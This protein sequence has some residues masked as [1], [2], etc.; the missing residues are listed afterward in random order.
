MTHIKAPYNF[1]PL[2]KDVVQPYW[3]R[4]ISHDIPFEDAQSGSLDVVLTAHS[5][6]F[7]KNGMRKGEEDAFYKNNDAGKRE[8][9][10]K[11]YPFNQFKGK[12]FIPGSS[13]KGMVRAVLEIMSFGRM[14]NK[15]N[16]HRYALRDFSPAMKDTYL[17]KFTPDEI[18]AGWLY[19][20][21]ENN[22]KII[23]CRHPGRISHRQLDE[24]LNTDFV[25]HF[26]KNGA[27]EKSC[28]ENKKQLDYYKSA[29]YKYDY[30]GKENPRKFAFIKSVVQDTSG[31]KRY[32]IFKND[33][34][35]KSDSDLGKGI[36]VFTGQTGPRDEK[37]SER[38]G[39]H[40]G[41]GHHL[42]FVFFSG[43]IEPLD[44]QGKVMDN[45]FFAYFEHDNTRWSEDYKIRREQLN[46]EEKI[47][48]FFQ[49]DENGDVKH[50]GLSYM[51]KVPFEHS[52][53]EAIQLH[54]KD[55][56]Y[57]LAEIIFGFTDADDKKF[58]KGRVHIGHAFATNSPE[59]DEEKL[60]VLSGPKASYYPNY[61]RQSFTNG[62]VRRY[63]SFMDNKPEIAGWKRYP[64]HSNGIK[65]NPAPLIKGKLNKKILTQFTPLKT[66]A[67]FKF[68]IRYHNLKKIELG[69]LLS[70][71]TF[72][73]TPNTFHSIGMAKPLGYGKVNLAVSG[74]EN[75]EEC[76]CAFESYMNIELRH[77]V[78]EWGISEQMQDLISMVSEQQNSGKSELKYMKLN[79]EQRSNDFVNAKKA[80]E[81]LER[82]S[83]LVGST[84]MITPI[85]SEAQIAKMKGVCEAE[86]EALNKRLNIDV[87]VENTIQHKEEQLRILFEKRKRMLLKALDEKQESIR[88][89]EEATKTTK[90]EKERAERKSKAKEKAAA[91]LELYLQSFDATKRKAFDSLKKVL[92]NI[93]LKELNGLDYK[94]LLQQKGNGVLP[95]S[96]LEVL[97]ATIIEIVGNTKGKKYLERWLN[98]TKNGANL[99]KMEEWIGEE[100]AKELFNK[101]NTK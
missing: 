74:V 75:M 83:I 87:V 77:E 85:C 63:N 94:K 56:E 96:D 68:K 4:H 72:H 26:R 86:I 57:D 8:H 22:Y 59:I 43:N 12:Y 89:E 81:A 92:E 30:W 66:G 34:L 38:K 78:P 88:L 41:S 44:V 48:V 6:I 15:V 52:V 53:K 36:V 45:F 17:K 99:K 31:R 73:Q 11:P 93:Y 46:K 23:D 19:K 79:M 27:F 29:Q 62:K 3:T 71:L 21:K 42:E 50:L 82:Y 58:L 20:D 65:K 98:P 80:N 24:D 97:T 49:K 2:N 64:I 90:E 40:V 33:I 10:D 1:V 7:V 5:P 55:T 39:L 100:K 101:L 84:K 51:Y 67:E 69:A 32:Q 18:F 61:I 13:L 91:G 25:N 16:D 76:L 37:Y 9:Q 95:E 35:S 60:E 28:R 47:P 54:Q 70:A 14:E